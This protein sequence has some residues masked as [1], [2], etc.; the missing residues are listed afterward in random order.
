MLPRLDLNAGGNIQ[1]TTI[2]QRFSNGLEVNTSGVRG[3]GLNASADLGWTLFDGGR[4]F[5]NYNSLKANST[6][7]NIQ[8][9]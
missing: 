1:G 3:N 4:M 9:N 2:N 5:I 6:L 7:S 8:L